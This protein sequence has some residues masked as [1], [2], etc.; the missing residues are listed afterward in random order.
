MFKQYGD[1]NATM[2][3]FS[4]GCFYNCSYC[5]YNV[6]NQLQSKSPGLITQEIQELN[7]LRYTILLKDEIALNPNKKIFHSQM[8]AIGNENIK[9]RGQ[10]TSV[11]T[12]EHL[13]LASETG[14]LELS[15]GVETVDNNVIKMINKKWQNDKIIKTFIENAKNYGIKIKMCL[16]FG[17]QENL[18]ILLKKQLNL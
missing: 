17:L 12:D 11:G 10:T 15:V 8:E 3:Y 13:K 16:I 2:V 18:G 7:Q 4:R 6:P 1:Y 14:C 5:V 9:W